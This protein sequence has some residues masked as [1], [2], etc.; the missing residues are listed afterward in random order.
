MMH[1]LPF[2][3]E[4]PWWSHFGRVRRAHSHRFRSPSFLDR[5]ILSPFR[6]KEPSARL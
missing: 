4:P 5:F 2:E 6:L 1:A 3:I